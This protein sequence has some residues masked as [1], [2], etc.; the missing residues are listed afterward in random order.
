MHVLDGNENL[1]VLILVQMVAV[2]SSRVC[3]PRGQLCSDMCLPAYWSHLID[4]TLTSSLVNFEHDCCLQD[5]KMRPGVVAHA[6]NPRHLVEK[7]RKIRV[8]GQPGKDPPSQP[9]SWVSWCTPP[10]IRDH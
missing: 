10:Y 1:L 9:V 5:V 4:T 7:I 2:L 3:D 8:R 6:Y